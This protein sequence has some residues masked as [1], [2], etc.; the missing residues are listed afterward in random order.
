MKNWPQNP[1]LDPQHPSLSAERPHF[2][3]NSE[4]NTLDAAILRHLE[5]LRDNQTLPWGIS[6]LSAF[7]D[8]PGFRRVADALEQVGK[9][10]LLLGADPLP[11]ASRDIPGP[12]ADREPRRSRNLLARALQ[13]LDEGLCRARDL[14]PFD[15]QTDSTV[16]RLIDLLDSAKIEVRRCEDRFL[17]AKAILF[18]IDGGGVLAG[19]ANFS[20]AGMQEPT[21][22]TLGHYQD[23]VVTRVVD[24]FE[25]LWTAAVPYDLADLY[26]RLMTDYPPYL[27]YLAVLR[28]LYGDELEEEQEE[29]GQIPVTTFQKHGVW[30][31]LKILQ[32]FNGVL[33]ADGVGLGKTF[34]AGEIITRYVNRRQRV[35]LI[36]PAALRDNTWKDFLHRFWLSHIECLSYEQLAGDRQ[37]GGNGNHLKS[38]LDEYA[39]VVIDEAHNYRNPD[40]PARAGVLRQLLQGPRRDLVLMTATPV[41][42]SLWDLYHLLRYFV[43][44]DAVLADRGVLSLRERFVDAMSEDPF[45][46]NPD[47]LF[48]VIDATTVKRTR[49][50]VKKH[51]TNDLIKMADGRQVKISFP[52]PIPSTIKYD[53]D[54]V[55]PGF[56]DRLE[57][58]LMP[59]NEQPE[60]TLARYQPERYPAGDK[61]PGT[62]LP[63]VG[64]LRSGLL[65]R[66]ES[67]SDAFAKTTGKMVREH[68]LFLEGLKNDVIIEK[69]VIRELSAASDDDEIEELLAEPGNTLPTTGYNVKRLRAAV[70]SD[71][72][73]LAE[74]CKQAESVEPENDPKLAELVEEL[75]RIARTADKESLDETERRRKRKVLIFS[76]YEDTID[77]IEKF[78]LKVIA[79]DKRLE[80]Y[81]GRLATVAGRES[82]HGINREAAVHGFAPESSGAPP[83][84]KGED[85]D[86]YDLLL[87]TDVLAEGM[88]LQQCRNIVNYDLPWNPMRLVQRHGR[89]DRIGSPHPRVF[90]R[91]F[92]PDLQLDRLLDLEMRVRRKLAQAAAS[93][94]VEAT[95]IEGGLERDQSFAETREEIERLAR[96]DPSLY[97]QGG[98]AGAAQS[99]EEYRQDLRKA[100]EE[101]PWKTS[102]AE[103]PW[104]A[105]SGLVKGKRRGHFFCARIGERVYLRF[106]PTDGERLIHEIGT[107]LRLIECTPE[108]ERVVP[109]DLH[110][111]VHAAWETARQHIYE[112]WQRETDPANLQPRVR[113]LNH[114]IAQF[115][116]KSPPAG[117]EQSRLQRCLDAIEAPCSRRE[118]NQLREVFQKDYAG[119]A[120]KAKAIIE[121]VETIGLEPFQ[122]PHPLP[123]IRPDEVH[124]VCWLAVES[125]S[126]EPAG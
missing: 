114:E 54:A 36:C 93:V 3:D 40:A 118:E 102:L 30:R 126:S 116:R 106:V 65:K 78:L 18:D 63:I 86:K 45:N 97:D 8:V 124:L 61:T 119:K 48:P 31:A 26:R 35:L 27:I 43:K 50:F 25:D 21:S 20:L 112:A 77:Y 82:R 49:Q 96:N 60:L 4:G 44:Q 75:V 101:E 71:R 125:A 5:A 62:D 90:L 99:G 110:Q 92:F 42:N 87:C 98:T 28:E 72:D 83:A 103:L 38:Q 56:F 108:T 53:L 12:G 117:V 100:L 11:E 41:N 52:K 10:R 33:I 24:W 17:P 6:I 85:W 120:A 55:L 66:F 70:Q 79:E 95:P 81:Q 89:I 109:S 88:N 13:Q 94:G 9:V 58:A 115:L 22:L 91:T 23:P 122:A 107:C 74:L 59:T 113:K 84:K 47:M 68:D 80:C 34:L 39:L 37:F 29:E 32:K 73:L 2:V 16:R 64:L 14:L 46:L 76:Y 123:T 104:K 105:G 121:A 15:L 69:T 111:G 51:Y 19:T 1:G 67:S 7:F 57:Q